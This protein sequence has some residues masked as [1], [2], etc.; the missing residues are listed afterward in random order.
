MV[1]MKDFDRQPK[2]SETSPMWLESFALF[3]GAKERKGNFS[4]G[5]PPPVFFYL[6]ILVAA[7]VR[8][9]RGLFP[10]AE[11]ELWL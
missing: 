6:A 4:L 5:K 7:G 8:I 11:A 9:L 3:T 10:A 1:V 2:G